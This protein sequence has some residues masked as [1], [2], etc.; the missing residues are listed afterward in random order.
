TRRAEQKALHLGTSEILHGLALLRGLDALRRG[1]HAAV[2]GDAHHRADD[3]GRG[4]ITR[5]FLDEGTVDL[6]LVERKTLQILQRGIA[7]SEFVE[8]DVN[9]ERAKLVQRRE[10]RVVVRNQYSFR[11]FQLETARVEPG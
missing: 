11:D 10:R 6:D 4:G 5:H 1:D 7:G 3:R 9:P 8:R 2:G